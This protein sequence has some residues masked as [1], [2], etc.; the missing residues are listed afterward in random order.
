[1][2]II[3]IILLQGC[4]HKSLIKND[5]EMRTDASRVC[6]QQQRG[7]ARQKRPIADILGTVSDGIDQVGIAA[8]RS[9]RSRATEPVPDL[10]IDDYVH[11]VPDHV[12]YVHHDQDVRH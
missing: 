2:I 4:S 11:H 8:P 1:M 9:S 5:V 3:T 12:R 10:P 6:H 7:M